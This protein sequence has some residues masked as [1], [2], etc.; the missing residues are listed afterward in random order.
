MKNKYIFQW[1]CLCFLAM[2]LTIFAQTTRITYP[3]NGMIFQQN[4]SGVANV[5]LSVLISGNDA[6][7]TTLTTFGYYIETLDATGQVQ[8]VPRIY[9]YGLTATLQ[10]NFFKLL[11]ETISNLPKGWYRITF[12]PQF[13]SDIILCSRVDFGVGDVY[14]VAGQ[15]NASGY[16]GIIGSENDPID[17]DERGSIQ[18]FT[19]AGT[20]QYDAVRGIISDVGTVNTTTTRGLPFGILNTTTNATG[21]QRLSNGSSGNPQ[22]IYPNGRDSW[23]WVPFANKVA[24]EGT[25]VML[26]NV[27][28]PSTIMRDWTAND[29]IIN[30][31][32]KY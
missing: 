27:A 32:F 2:P 19:N 25:P 1:L 13:V 17:S 10:A 16:G 6:T 23:S 30:N 4:G 26:F 22:G 31:V 14:I 3:I 15:S 9:R 5:P 29:E 21:F 8:N 18:S 24:S 12:G 20:S 28:K 7:N 11:N